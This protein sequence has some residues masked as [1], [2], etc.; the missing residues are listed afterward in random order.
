MLGS[1]GQ[2]HALPKILLM[3]LA[4]PFATS[5]AR[6]CQLLRN[7]KHR[8]ICGHFSLFHMA[9]LSRTWNTLAS[10]ISG[11]RLE[12]CDPSRKSLSV[13]LSVNSI[14][15]L[16]KLSCAWGG[17]SAFASQGSTST[18]ASPHSGA[19]ALVFLIFPFILVNWDHLCHESP[20]TCSMGNFWREAALH[21]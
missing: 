9:L 15:I 18:G 10:W 8:H 21:F 7:F 1:A 19:A 16:N 5:T 20:S 11:R 14:S 3:D 4:A 6:Q 17:K 2:I 13:C 12:S